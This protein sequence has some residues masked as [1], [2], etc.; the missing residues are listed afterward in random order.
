MS[1]TEEEQSTAAELEP[2]VEKISTEH[3]FDVRGYK[4]TTL[5]RRIRKRMSDA[6]ITSV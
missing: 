3:G 1:E 5:Y 4:R 6:H 2:V